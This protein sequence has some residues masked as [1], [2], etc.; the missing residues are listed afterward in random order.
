MRLELEAGDK[1]ILD[2]QPIRE[3]ILKMV[4]KLEET[5]EED[6]IFY[7]ADSII[8][9]ILGQLQDVGIYLGDIRDDE[10]EDWRRDGETP[11]HY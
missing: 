1:I 6:E 9:D 11:S 3:T 4:D 5:L 8:D 7:N 2:S 10:A